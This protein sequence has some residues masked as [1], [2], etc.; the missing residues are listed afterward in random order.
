[1]VELFIFSIDCA[2]GGRRSQV[3]T[4]LSACL[5][6]GC[7]YTTQLPVATSFQ[8]QSCVL[9]KHPPKLLFFWFFL[10]RHS[11][12]HENNVQARLL[13]CTNTNTK[14]TSLHFLP[15]PH[16]NLILAL[17][18]KVHSYIIHKHLHKQVCAA[19]LG[20]CNMQQPSE[21]RKKEHF[22]FILSP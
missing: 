22:L 13:L 8:S 15:K 21:I 7:S 14:Q 1:M 18:N 9:R 19:R 11:L 16:Q 2:W 3:P 17:P 12:P 5:A 4:G 10:P 6:D 20:G